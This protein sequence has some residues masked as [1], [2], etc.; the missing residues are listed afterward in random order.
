MSFALNLT[1][2]QAFDQ[3]VTHMRT[4]KGIALNDR[5]FCMY[6]SPEGLK[7]AVG[8]LVPDDQYKPNFEG[9]SASSLPIDDLEGLFLDQAQQ[10]LH[11]NFRH[12]GFDLTKFEQ[13]AQRFAEEHH[14]KVN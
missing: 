1:K 14:L 3:M 2:Q 7:C 11:D 5:G 9:S 8:A 10:A 13:A 6:R 4:Q 12:D